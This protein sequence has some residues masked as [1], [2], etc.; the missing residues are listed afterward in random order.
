MTEIMSGQEVQ[1]KVNDKKGR[2]VG[3]K[4]GKG[5]D[6]V[7][8]EIAGSTRQV[9]VRDFF[10]RYTVLLGD[11]QQINPTAPKLDTNSSLTAFINQHREF[12]E[13]NGDGLL[14]LSEAT[15]NPSLKKQIESVLKE[16]TE[17][18]YVFR[19]DARHPYADS[20]YDR[21]MGISNGIFEKGF[22]R[23][24]SNYGEVI[25]TTPQYDNARLYPTFTDM[26]VGWDRRSFL[27]FIDPHNYQGKIET[28]ENGDVVFH[29]DIEPSRIKYCMEIEDTRGKPK[30]LG[31]YKN[32]IPAK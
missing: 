23:E 3:I 5:G 26:P 13:G 1:S 2:V 16:T 7:E 31:F 15:E 9:S 17:R 32:S 30:V 6:F 19:N 25:D 21:N 18:G 22:T 10:N 14:T 28:H 11:S 12:V 27:Y 4:P 24:G 20:D 8:V 29:G